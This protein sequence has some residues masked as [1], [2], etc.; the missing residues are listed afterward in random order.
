MANPSP[1]SNPRKDDF[2]VW[3]WPRTMRS[4]E[5]TSELQSHSDLVCRLLH[6]KKKNSKGNSYTAQVGRKKCRKTVVLKGMSSVNARDGCDC[7]NQVQRGH[8]GFHNAARETVK[9]CV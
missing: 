1:I 6:E 7:G 4:E 2:M 9:A 5:H 8:C 3:I